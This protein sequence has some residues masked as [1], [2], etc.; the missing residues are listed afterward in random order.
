MTLES[1][2]PLSYTL[3]MTIEHY[4]VTDKD[5]KPIAAQIPWDQFQVIK[6]EMEGDLPLDPDAKALFDRRSQ[7]L[8]DGT[9]EGISSDEMFKRVRERLEEKRKTPKSA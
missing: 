7:E 2:V 8:R 9:A 1:K 5:G 3:T 4:I 6:A